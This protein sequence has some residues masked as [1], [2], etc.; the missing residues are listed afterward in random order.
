MSCM[1]DLKYW[2]TGSMSL[3][4]VPVDINVYITCLSEQQFFFIVESHTVTQIYI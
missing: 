2:N 4:I 3:D 1:G